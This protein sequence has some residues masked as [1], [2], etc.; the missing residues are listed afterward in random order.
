MTEV[1]TDNGGTLSAKVTG[2]TLTNRYETSVVVNTTATGAEFAQKTVEGTGFAARD[3]RFTM[4]GGNLG[5]QRTQTVNFS[6][7][8]TKAIDFG[9]ITYTEA[10]TYSYTVRETAVAAEG[11]TFDLADHTVTVTV[12]DTNGTLSARVS[13]TTLT[14][15]WVPQTYPVTV[16]YVDLI[17]GEDIIPPVIIQVPTGGSYSIESPD[18]PGYVLFGDEIVTGTVTNAGV[19]RVVPYA[20]VTEPGGGPAGGGEP[21]GEGDPEPPLLLYTLID[22]DD[23]ETPL[24]LGG[25]NLN[26]GECIE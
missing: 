3:F 16:R 6:E 21:S 15:R 25:L 18:I 24:G 13:G 14:N 17:T 12:T 2:T 11:W 19:T 1:V 7:A 22:I 9:T 20:P 10:G 26:V 23:L 5:A 4:S 8:G